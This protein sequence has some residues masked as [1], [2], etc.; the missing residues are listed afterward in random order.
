MRWLIGRKIAK[1]ANSYPSLINRPHSGWPLS[2]FVMNQIFSETGMIR[3]SDGEEIM[4]LAFFVL[5]QYLSVTD[6]RTD[7]HL[8]SA[9]TS[10]CIACYANAGKKLWPCYCSW[11]RACHC[12]LL[13]T[14]SQKNPDTWDIFKYLQQSWTNINNFWHR[15]SSINMLLLM[16]TILQYLVKQRTSLGFPLATRRK[17]GAP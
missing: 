16:L 15:E 17:A 3:L 13:Y 4:T 2:N 9:Y 14:V 10:A 12:K 11:N 8:F 1:I 6:R 7:G 5:I